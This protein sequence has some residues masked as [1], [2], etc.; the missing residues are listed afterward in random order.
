MSSLTEK[1]VSVPSQSREEAA[2]ASER[3]PVSERLGWG[4]HDPLGALH[5][6][7]PPEPVREERR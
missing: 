1:N 7:P 4:P 2:P 6:T 5:F 3:P